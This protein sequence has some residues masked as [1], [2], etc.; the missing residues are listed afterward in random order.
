M[1]PGPVWRSAHP[2]RV[3]D[4]SRPALLPKAG[5]QG[6]GPAGPGGD[7]AAPGSTTWPPKRPNS[8]FDD[9]VERTFRPAGPNQL[10][11]VDITHH[12]TDDEWRYLGGVSGSF[13]RRVL[14]WARCPTKCQWSWSYKRY[15]WRLR[16]V[17][18]TR[19]SFGIQMTECSMR[20]CRSRSTC[21][22]RPCSVRLGA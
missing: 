11:V 8:L 18:P 5:N 9:L 17:I 15:Q 22:S 2:R 14:R 6:D 13:S 10:G 19:V 21:G 4:R 3:G 1:E 7:P 16:P 12:M 20:L